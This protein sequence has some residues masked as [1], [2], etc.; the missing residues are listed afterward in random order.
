MFL[1][2]ISEALLAYDH[3]LIRFLQA[4]EAK[5]NEDAKALF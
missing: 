1:F 2:D 4:K 5:L 3:N